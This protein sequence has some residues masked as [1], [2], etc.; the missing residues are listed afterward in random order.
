MSRERR[1]RGGSVDFG[2]TGEDECTVHLRFCPSCV[3][4]NNISIPFQELRCPYWRLLDAAQ[5][6]Q[7]E[8]T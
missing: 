1:H 3:V 2:G 6:Q 7:A 8:S 5:P 4:G